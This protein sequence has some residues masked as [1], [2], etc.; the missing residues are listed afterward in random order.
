VAVLQ[1]NKGSLTAD[2][3]ELRGFSKPFIRVLREIRGLDVV[4]NP[5]GEQDL[6]G[7]QCDKSLA[8]KQPGAGF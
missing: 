4:R 7:L 3:A 5:L 6:D 1:P 8:P 2:D